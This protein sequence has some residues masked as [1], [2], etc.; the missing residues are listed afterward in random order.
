MI[1]AQQLAGGNVL[2]V[3]YHLL[4]WVSEILVDPEPEL[5]KREWIWNFGIASSW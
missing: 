5:E 3:D 2:P 4:A 1:I